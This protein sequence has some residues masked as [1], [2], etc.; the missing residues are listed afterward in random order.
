MRMPV[1]EYRMRWDEAMDHALAAHDHLRAATWNR[2]R[3]QML[4]EIQQAAAHMR[5]MSDHLDQLKAAFL[6]VEHLIA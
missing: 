1:T 4:V 3:K 6:R 2:D 5:D